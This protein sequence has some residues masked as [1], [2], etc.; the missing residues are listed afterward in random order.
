[1]SNLG[2]I[3]SWIWYA[4]MII[5]V[6]V[7]LS[8]LLAYYGKLKTFKLGHWLVVLGFIACIPTILS[9][10]SIQVNLDPNQV[11]VAKHRLLGIYTVGSAFV[12]ACLRMALLKWDFPF[13]PIYYLGLTALMIA[14]ISWTNDYG[15][16]I[17]L[18]T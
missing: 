10:F 15:L 1:M 5:F 18:S 11:F 3:H 8:D 13:K 6:T 14:L 17:K 7:F 12:Y 16:L 9:G 4:P 2:H